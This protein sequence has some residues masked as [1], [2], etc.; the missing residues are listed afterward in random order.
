MRKVLP[1]AVSLVMAAIACEEKTPTGPSRVEEITAAPNAP[2]VVSIAGPAELS[3]AAGT[4]VTFTATANDDT[5]GM[6]DLLVWRSNIE[7]AELGRGGS[8][9]VNTGDGATP[10]SLRLGTH[11]ITATVENSRGQEGFANVLVTITPPAPPGRPEVTITEMPSVL[12][13]TSLFFRGT[14]IDAEDGDI[15]E[16]IQWD[17]SIDGDLGTGSVAIRTGGLSVGT[18]IVTAKAIDSDGNLGQAAASVEVSPVPGGPGGPNTPPV[19]TIT[20]PPATERNIP[21][22]RLIVFIGTAI[23][24]EDGDISSELVWRSNID[25]TMG[26]IGSSVSEPSLS[27]GTHMIT[28]A[29]TDR[30]G[31]TT[32]AA[33]T[34]TVATSA[35][36]T[37]TQR[38]VA[39]TGTATATAANDLTL[40][41]QLLDRGTTPT[42]G[43]SPTYAVSGNWSA[44]SGAHSGAITGT[45][46]GLPDG[47]TL[48]LILSQGAGTCLA[49]A[50]FTG[51]VTPTSLRLD[52]S[53]QLPNPE[54]GPVDPA[55]CLWPAGFD[56]FVGRPATTTETAPTP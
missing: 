42:V 28:A 15:S 35:P 56:T 37:V 27:V 33:I 39:V 23:D 53:S 6:T 25:G 17:S 36:T 34:L 40:M 16:L 38:F 47:G 14:A 7:G 3:F 26:G 51:R 45:L 52:R 41:F 29:A 9:T 2:P 4:R 49:E 10:P 19:V 22:G 18:H 8:V 48:D 11:T 20:S 13:D 55:P 12:T 54:T 46:T 44:P 1:V 5:G 50:E 32:T 24:P 30:G 43:V 31:M 21:F